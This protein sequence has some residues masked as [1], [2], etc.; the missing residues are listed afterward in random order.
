LVQGW[1]G[2]Q[3]SL[4]DVALTGAVLLREPPAVSHV[5]DGSFYW[6]QVDP[7]DEVASS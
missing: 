2:V 6:G 3:A 1:S 4:A 7:R 5:T